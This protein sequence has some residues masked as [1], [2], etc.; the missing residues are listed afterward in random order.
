MVRLSDGCVL[1]VIKWKMKDR[2][3]IKPVGHLKF[4]ITNYQY[5]LF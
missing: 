2:S 5:I 4:N 1:A 3:Q